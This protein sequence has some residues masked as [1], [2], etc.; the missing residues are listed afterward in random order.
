MEKKITL[1]VF[2]ITLFSFP[3]YEFKFDSYAFYL[4]PNAICCLVVPSCFRG[5]CRG[6]TC[7]ACTAWQV[8]SNHLTPLSF[9]CTI[10]THDHIHVINSF[11]FCRYI[12]VFD[13]LDGSSNIDCGVSIGTV[14][15]FS[16]LIIVFEN[17]NIEIIL[18]AS[19]FP[20]AFRSLVFTWSRIQ[21]MLPL[22]MRCNLGIIC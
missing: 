16:I 3:W 20:V 1:S 14:R 9:N 21:L 17:F 6:Y 11:L 4:A 18:M 8:S 10:K 19:I 15:I 2:F 5:E 13:P 12:V 7:A 22:K